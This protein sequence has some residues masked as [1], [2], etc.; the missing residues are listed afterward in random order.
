[1]LIY[2][3]SNIAM[4]I[5]SRAEKKTNKI[6]VLKRYMRLYVQTLFILQSGFIS[7]KN[8][9]YVMHVISMV[10]KVS[11]HTCRSVKIQQNGTIY[12]PS[13]RDRMCVWGLDVM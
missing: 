7:S 5:L 2:S 4:C 11:E 13:V 12:S 9:L 8:T 6:D 10:Y 3:T 1:M